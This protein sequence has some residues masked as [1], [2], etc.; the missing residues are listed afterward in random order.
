MSSSILL[1]GWNLIP[2][3]FK[4]TWLAALASGH[5]AVT[6]GQGEVPGF[7]AI[8][9]LLAQFDINPSTTMYSYR[10]FVQQGRDVTVWDQ[11]RSG[12]ILGS[13]EYVNRLKPMFHAIRNVVEI[14]RS[15]RLA[16]RRSLELIFADAVDR[17]TRNVCI[18]EATR[19]HGYTLKEVGN[20]LGLY[21]STIST[22]AKR[23][24]E[25]ETPRKKT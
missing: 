17:P 9:W 4:P 6:A 18:Y 11:V 7:L 13:D 5:G 2:V 15:E 24:D 20:H 23:V 14:S 3:P 22:I 12:S 1:G 25:S 21:Y 8:D 10:E 19:V 16:A